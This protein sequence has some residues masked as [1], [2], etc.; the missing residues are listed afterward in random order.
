MYDDFGA[1]NVRRHM[2][3]ALNAP[4]EPVREINGFFR[5]FVLLLIVLFGAT[6]ILGLGWILSEAFLLLS[7]GVWFR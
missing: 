7:K 5:T 6:V 2:E 1:D 4:E 3:G